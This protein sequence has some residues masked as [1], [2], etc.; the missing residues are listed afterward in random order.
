LDKCRVGLAQI[1]LSLDCFETTSSGM[2]ALR[3]GHVD[4]LRRKLAAMVANAQSEHVDM[5]LFP[6]LAIDLKI[7]ALR[8]DLL[9]L[10]NQTGMTIVPGSYH[11]VASRRNVTSVIGPEGILWEQEKQLPA[12][13][14][15]G[16]RRIEEAILPG[17]KSVMVVNTR[18]GR[19]AIVI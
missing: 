17:P 14:Q 5:L 4:E 15:I 1:S 2:L 9:A 8:A 10:A 13:M 19:I 7:D 18:F 6:E 16:E 12:I 11:D 3:D